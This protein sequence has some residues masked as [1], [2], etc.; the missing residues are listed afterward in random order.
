MYHLL[1]VEEDV[2]STILVDLQ[3]LQPILVLDYLCRVFVG[4]KVTERRV[5]DDQ[6]G[7]LCHFFVKGLEM[8]YTK[9]I[10]CNPNSKYLIA[11]PVE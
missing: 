6:L 11:N 3:P 8:L 2:S 9:H 4:H 10:L 1:S 5:S 7:Y